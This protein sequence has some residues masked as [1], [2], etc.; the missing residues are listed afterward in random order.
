VRKKLDWLVLRAFFGPFVVTFFVTLFVLVMQFFWLYMDELIG[1]GLPIG[2]ILQLLVLMS[3]TMV[4]LALPL[5]IL[6]ASIMTL[7]S[8]GEAFELVAIKSAGISLLRFLRPLAVAALV[9][10]GAA[11]LFNNYVIPVANLK[12]LSMLYDLRNSKPTLNIRAGMF[13]RD[14][15]GYAIRVGSKDADGKTIRNIAIYDHTED[16][17]N[18]KSVY[19]RRGQ[20]IPAADNRSLT[21]RLEDGWRF[22]E[23]EG[24]GRDGVRQQVRMHFKR[25]DMVFDLSSLG[26]QSTDQRLFAGDQKM[27]SVHQLSREIDTIGKE[28]T[29]TVSTVP[30]YLKPYIMFR[31]QDL[32]SALFHKKLAAT[33]APPGAVNVLAR[34]PD[35][36]RLTAIQTAIGNAR[37]A[38]QLVNISATSHRTASERLLKFQVE[39]HRK[40][41]LA[42]ACLLLFLIGAPLGSIIRKGGIGMPLLV[43]IV[44]FLLWYIVSFTGESLVTSGALPP[45]AGMWM[46]TVALL[47]LAVFLLARAQAD[48]QIFSREWYSRAL[49]FLRA[50]VPAAR[51]RKILH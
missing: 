24:R 47:P 19:A 38:A 43:A 22:E 25:W 39:R 33:K 5:A 28:Q 21:F 48:S 36:L 26:I 8:M 34:I 31:S 14:I 23:T 29:R 40:F 27:M 1:K 51:A 35:S 2:L 41:T 30:G 50:L 15:E 37:N 12:A 6:M 3:T 4:P 18:L 17:R 20:M 10:S 13:N 46:S 16:D 11:F 49:V 45:A 9:L 44:F 7:G 42:A 32:D